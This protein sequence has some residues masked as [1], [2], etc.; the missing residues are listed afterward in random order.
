L[1]LI[2]APND[3]AIFFKNTNKIKG[4][5][6][7]RSNLETEPKR[8]FGAES[9]ADRRARKWNAYS[10]MTKFSSKQLTVV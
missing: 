9:R 5:N 1:I 6:L 2:E 7:V 4:T 8:R 3:T 10:P